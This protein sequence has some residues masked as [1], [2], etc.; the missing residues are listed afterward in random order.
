VLASANSR[1]PGH[2]INQHFSVTLAQTFS[3]S[4]AMSAP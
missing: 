3:L 2:V 1:R 4:Q